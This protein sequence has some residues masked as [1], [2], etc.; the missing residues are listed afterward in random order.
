MDIKH[1]LLRLEGR[2]KVL[3]VRIPALCK[4]AGIHPQTWYAWKHG[5]SPSLKRWKA[6]HSVMDKLES[7]RGGDA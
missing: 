4:M 7:D 3:E 6:I 2:A 1:D 5:A